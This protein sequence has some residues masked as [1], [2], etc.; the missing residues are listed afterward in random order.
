MEWFYY[1]CFQINDKSVFFSVLCFN[2]LHSYYWYAAHINKS[3]LKSK[4]GSRHQNFENFCLQFALGDIDGFVTKHKVTIEGDL[5]ID[6]FS[7]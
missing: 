3:S 4:K 2:S 5:D 6:R 1:C 7:R